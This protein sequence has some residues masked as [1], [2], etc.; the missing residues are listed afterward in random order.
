MTTTKLSLFL[1]CLFAVVIICVYD[2]LGNASIACKIREISDL[3]R[4]GN[5]L[6]LPSRS[7]TLMPPPSISVVDEAK[8]LEQKKKEARGQREKQ[9]ITKG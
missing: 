6:A 2:P 5:L 7:S 3:G 8:R 1:V 9:F 4:L